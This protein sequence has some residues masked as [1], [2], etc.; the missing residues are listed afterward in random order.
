MAELAVFDP[1]PCVGAY[2]TASGSGF[3][4]GEPI[5]LSRDG[6]LLITVPAAADGTFSAR[7]DIST[8]QGGVHV[9]TAVGTGSGYT[10]TGSFDVD[11]RV[12]VTTSPAGT[13]SA[14]AVVSVTT[15]NSN[16]VALASTGFPTG[17]FVGIAALA[18]LA[19]SVL[20]FAVRRR[21][22]GG[23]PQH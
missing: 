10:A 20:L 4:P 9:V 16:T 15:A 12:C 13:G 14:V 5:A 2:V 21:V 23:S 18:M 8:I 7:V 6:V 1:G 17:T 19:G 11:S 22:A 3:T